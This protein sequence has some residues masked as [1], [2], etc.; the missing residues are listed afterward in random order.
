[1][2]KSAALTSEFARAF[3]SFLGH[4]EGT[5]KSA[6][7][8]KSYRLDLL[9]FERFLQI[10]PGP[11]AARL[12]L[13]AIDESVFTAYA[14]HLSTQGLRTNTRRRAL[15]TVQKFLRYLHGRKKAPA[16]AARKFPTPHKQERIPVTVQA[17]ALLARLRTLHPESPIER[18]NQLLLQVLLE[19][20]CLVAEVGALR[21]RDVEMRAG[22][23]W[24][25]FPPLPYREREVEI[26]QGL[27]RAL[28]A[29]SAESGAS[30][31]SPLF[32]GFNRHGSLGGAISPRGVEL[33]VG[34]W[35]ARLDAPDLTPRQIRHS[36]ALQ[37]LKEGV[38][39]AEVQR[40]LGLLSDY[41][42][43]GYRAIISSSKATSTRE[44]R[45]PES[46][47]RIKSD[48]SR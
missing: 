20:G 38:A 32:E 6:N 14:Q 5:Q 3:R 29:L 18:R 42:F 9:A 47:A 44:T 43:R 24:L 16:E 15:L 30:L 19:T 21:L 35:G 34:A 28:L 26:S 45:R 10:L 2:P 36:V 25:Q 37:W 27:G 46:A 23:W 33:L 11:R 40:R 31:N 39:E 1:M 41:A 17:D 8:I 22:K 7:T 13:Q 4:L 48:K 12:T